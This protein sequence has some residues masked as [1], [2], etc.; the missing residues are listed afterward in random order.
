LFIQSHVKK[1]RITKHTHEVLVKEGGSV[2]QK[3]IELMLKQQASPTKTVTTS[4][5]GYSTPCQSS[6]SLVR[7]SLLLQDFFINE[8]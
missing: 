3:T 8:K 1:P 5:E 2:C 7:S 6:V 4:D